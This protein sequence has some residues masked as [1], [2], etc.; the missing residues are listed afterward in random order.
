MEVSF[1]VKCKY[2]DLELLLDLFFHF[3]FDYMWIARSGEICWCF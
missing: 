2:V 3:K 1:S